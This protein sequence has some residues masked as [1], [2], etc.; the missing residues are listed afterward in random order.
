MW[1]FS[2]GITED[3]LTI[4]DNLASLI[5]SAHS[6][7]GPLDQQKAW[8]ESSGKG[9]HSSG[10]SSIDVGFHMF[11]KLKGSV[12]S[13]FFVLLLSSEMFLPQQSRQKVC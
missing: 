5:F 1:N 9:P 7:Q 11:S 4:L 13:S 3:A 8:L 2:G 6:L 12:G 10:S